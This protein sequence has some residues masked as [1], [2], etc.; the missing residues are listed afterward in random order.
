[1]ARQK[2]G[3]PFSPHA[4]NL[5]FNRPE[6]T[7][8]LS[9]IYHAV[10]SMSKHALHAYP[11]LA[12]PRAHFNSS[13]ALKTLQGQGPVQWIFTIDFLVS[14]A[15]MK[16]KVHAQ[17]LPLLRAFLFWYMHFLLRVLATPLHGM[18]MATPLHA[19]GLLNWSNIKN[20]LEAKHSKIDQLHVRQL[21]G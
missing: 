14:L 4:N 18:P 6:L 9:S 16:A 19:H 2:G 11:L 12:L 20:P 21:E 5:S 1:M 13:R 17:T 10:L 3:G 7:K 8:H 15:G